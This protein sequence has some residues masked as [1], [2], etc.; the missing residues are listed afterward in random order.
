MSTMSDIQ[1]PEAR[2]FTL[3]TV[4]SPERR[5]GSIHV[6][7]VGPLQSPE[8]KTYLSIDSPVGRRQYLWKTQQPNHVLELSFATGYQ[9]SGAP[10]N[11]ISDRGP[12]F[13]SSL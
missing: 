5:F 1:N 2:P 6:D 3:V 8:N 4:P 13:T 10:D 9:G 7:I 12:Q 11:L